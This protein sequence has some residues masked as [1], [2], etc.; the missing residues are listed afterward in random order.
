[1]GL[2]KNL[3]T[4]AK[5]NKAAYCRAWN[6]TH[7]EKVKAY[8]AAWRRAHPEACRAAKIHSYKKN[9]QKYHATIMA[10]K[11][12][13]PKKTK[14]QQ[15]RSNAKVRSTAQ[16]CLNASMSSRIC[17]ALQSGKGNH[18]WLDLVD[19]S[20]AQLKKHIEKQFTEG[21]SWE[22][23]IKGEI[24]IDHII[25]VSAFNFTNPKDIDF[26][27]CWS[28]KNLQPLWAKENRSKHAKLTQPFQPSLLIGA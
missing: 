26:K 5:K 9:P 15:H 1:M 14:A 7:P 6:K 2:Y 25:P 19:F 24:H 28:L 12:A 21:M 18:H 20:L 17:L 3:S 27:K 16:G 13:N 22:L 8:S 4:A 11:K 23:Y 10:W